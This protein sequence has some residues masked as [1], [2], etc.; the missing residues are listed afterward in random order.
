MSLS[1]RSLTK[2]TL[3]YGIGTILARFVTFLLLPLYTNVL[4]PEDYG[5]TSLVF[6]FL[7]FMNIIYN[8]GLDSALM[9]Y[10]SKEKTREEKRTILST[11]VILSTVTSLIFTVIIY[12][13]SNSLSIKLLSKGEYQILIKYASFILFFDCLARLP[14]A[15]LRLKERAFTFMAIKIANVIV[16][17]SL[18]IYLVAIA[19]KGI[20]GIFISNLITSALTTFVAF[21]FLLRELKPA[22]STAYATSLVLFGLPFVPAGLATVTMEMLNRYIIG[23]LMDLNAVGI[24]SAGFKLGI[25]ML[26]ITTAFYYAWQ[27]FFLK[28]G[29]K[30]SSKSLFSRVLTYFTLTMMTVW[31]VLTVFIR[32]IVNFHI[33]DI[34]LVGKEYQ[35]CVEIVPYILLGYVFYGINLVFLPGI[36]FEKKT[37]F[38][39]YNTIISAL[40]NV[41]FNFVLIPIIGIIGSAV[42]SML[43]YLTLAI[44]SYSVSQKLFRVEYEY[45]RI[46]LL[47]SIALIVGW[48]L[49]YFE[50]NPLIK[51][52]AVLFFPIILKILGFFKKHEIDML[53]KTFKI[54]K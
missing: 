24:F 2:Q 7:G 37:Q 54:L 52:G 15:Y 8:Y 26:L 45:K 14:F 41:L 5:L 29:K 34:Y 38:I 44:C 23:H 28:A 46:A 11:A 21:I 18:N 12:L 49:F 27:P 36:Y 40:V 39:A 51:I 50:P 13:L 47:I 20:N 32:E 16:V 1:I 25:F 19:G 17:F 3:I 30:E 4:S 53:K 31:L 10:Y 9:R 22:F 43:G 6:A 35:S 48:T 33:G 42:A